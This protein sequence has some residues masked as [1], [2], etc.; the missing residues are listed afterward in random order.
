[1]DSGE[2]ADSGGRRSIKDKVQQLNEKIKYTMLFII[3]YVIL[4]LKNVLTIKTKL[5]GYMLL[6]TIS[7]NIFITE[8][9]IDLQYDGGM[10]GD[11]HNATSNQT[12]APHYTRLLF[13]SLSKKIILFHMD[14]M[15]LNLLSWS[16][17]VLL[18]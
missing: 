15:S 8:L 4:S 9:Y 13:I 3:I 1:M 5:F 6:L 16:S 7:A 14:I 10:H 12:K 2:C 18:L 17:G 11:P